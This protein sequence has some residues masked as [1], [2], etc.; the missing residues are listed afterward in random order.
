MKKRIMWTSFAITA[1]ALIVFSILTTQ[2][3]YNN[4]VEYARHYLRGY[5][6]VFDETRSIEELDAAYAQELSAT[7]NGAR[8]TFLT[9][10]GTLI[11]DSEDEEEGSRALRPEV[12][13]A[14]ESGEGFDVRTS[15]TLGVDFLY[16]CRQFD[17][18][19]VRIAERTQ[20]LWDVLLAS[21][22]AVLVYLVADAAVCLLLTYL[23]TGYILQPLEELG[24]QA[25]Y[26]K[27]V[28]ATVPELEQFAAIVNK[29]NED[30]EQR[31]REIDEE[32]EQAIKA[33]SSKD[34]FIANVTHE[35][36]TPLT[37]IHG[38]AELLAS[39]ALEGERRQKALSTILTQSERLQSLVASIINYSEIDSEDLPT[40]E[41]DAS[42][43]LRE[44]L[45]ALSP[46]IR[47]HK[48]VLLSEVKEGVILNS[49]QERVTEIFGNI[50][51]NAIRYNRE[52]GSISVLLTREEFTVSDTGIGISE[53]NL[54]RIF[55]RFFT[56]DKSH[57]GKNGGFGLGLSVVRKLCKKQGWQL[58]VESK[59]GVGSTFRV[60]FPQENEKN[61]A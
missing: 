52:G 14:I 2:I 33:K 37:S 48:L 31:V 22:P 49:R 9:A 45:A 51:R 7:L 3:C 12:A 50:I 41:V 39:G 38:F 25:S 43:I 4:S 13:D 57:N 53:E 5:M 60:G 54:G 61:N 36:N 11:A 42:H 8:V 19:L 21:L 10:D 1:V 26:R 35:M 23:A 47:E 6:S 20:S 46:E 55:D 18:Y 24:K 28:K 27:K 32:R 40:Y 29:M 30:A 16:Y 15:P 58:S 34:E 17:G 44:T 59:E 56:V